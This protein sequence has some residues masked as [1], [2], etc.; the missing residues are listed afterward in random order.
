MIPRRKAGQTLSGQ[1]RCSSCQTYPA[2]IARGPQSFL[3]PYKRTVSLKSNKHQHST[4][5]LVQIKTNVHIAPKSVA[6]QNAL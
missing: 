6:P 2:C 3:H 1:C 5:S 4:R